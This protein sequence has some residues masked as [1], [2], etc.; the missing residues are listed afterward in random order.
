MKKSVLITGA[1]GGIGNSIC[2][3]LKDEYDLYLLGRQE[4][5]LIESSKRNP[6]VK[7]F[8]ICDLSNSKEIRSTI[9]KISNENINIDI[10]INNAG[11]TDDGLFIRMSEEKW[12]KVI[13]TNLNSNFLLTNLLSKSMIRQKWGRIINITSIVGHSGNIGQSNYSA[14][15]AGIIGMSKSVALELAKRNI[16]VNCISPGFI[17]TNMTNVL[18]ESQK[19]LIKSKIPMGIIG[20]PDDV[21]NCVYFL[22]SD[23]ASYITGETIHINGGMMML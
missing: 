20:K 11:I 23:K 16:T 22:V 10:L 8:F 12:E 4:S 7:K 14:S 5:K 1:T 15:K 17:D 13:N 18:T 21:A 3:V 2:D 6:S 19:E 9:D